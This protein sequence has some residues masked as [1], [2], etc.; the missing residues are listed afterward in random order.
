MSL[1]DHFLGQLQTESQSVTDNCLRETL[2]LIEKSQFSSIFIKFHEEKSTP[3]V[4]ARS[5]FFLKIWA[6]R[7]ANRVSRG[8]VVG[9]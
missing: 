1:S 3:V 7:V 2:F 5:G 9:D 4:A 8:G 6:L